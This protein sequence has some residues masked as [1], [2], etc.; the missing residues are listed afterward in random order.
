VGLISARTKP[1][2]VA[3]RFCSTLLISMKK[4]HVLTIEPKTTKSTL[5]GTAFRDPCCLCRCRRE[6]YPCKASST[7]TA[8]FACNKECG[9]QPL[10]VVPRQEAMRLTYAVEGSPR[11]IFLC[12]DRTSDHRRS[13]Q[14][15]GNPRLCRGG[16][17][18][19]LSSLA[20]VNNRNATH[21]PHSQNEAC[22][23]RD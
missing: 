18:R 8:S 19:S 16:R 23:L 22:G 15:G 3:T 2:R 11:R 17:R 12:T 7:T 5:K 4:K 6:I 9:A 10:P 14:L 1:S 20:N 13:A 21:V